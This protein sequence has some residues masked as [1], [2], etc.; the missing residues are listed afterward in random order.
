MLHVIRRRFAA[1]S[2]AFVDD[3]GGLSGFSTTAD[4]IH[5]QY[6]VLFLSTPYGQLL[7]GLVHNFLLVC[8]YIFLLY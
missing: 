7:K 3:D 8:F 5:C 2:S 6:L 4:D 1:T